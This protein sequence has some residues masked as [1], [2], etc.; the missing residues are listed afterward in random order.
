ML[1]EM[2]KYNYLGKKVRLSSFLYFFFYLKLSLSAKV[3]ES[4][5]FQRPFSFVS[6]SVSGFTYIRV[7]E[8][9]GKLFCKKSLNF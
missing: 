7:E 8:R 3:E 2:V 5:V 4:F 6:L 1:F 9:N